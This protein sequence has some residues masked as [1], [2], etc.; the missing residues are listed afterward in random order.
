MASNSPAPTVTVSTAGKPP[1]LLGTSPKDLRSFINAAKL[2]FTL[3]K[4][5]TDAEKI[6]WTGAGLTNFPELESW[7]L[8]N[9]TSHE[10]KTFDTFLADLQKRAL[11]FDFVWTMEGRIRTSKQGE[12]DYATWSQELRSDQ[13]LLTDKVMPTHELV[14]NLLFNMDDELSAILRR[15]KA[16]EGTGFHEDDQSA[17]FL[18]KD[19]DTKTNQPVDYEKFD[20]TARDEWERIAQRRAANVAQIKALAKKGATGSSTGPA[21]SGSNTR[22]PT[23]STSAFTSTTETATKLAKL[24]QHEKDW[25]SANAGCFKCRKLRAGHEARDCKEWAKPGEVIVIPAGWKTGTPVPPTTSTT[26]STSKAT[27]TVGAVQVDRGVDLPESFAED[28]DT[29][30]DEYALPLLRLV[31]GSGQKGTAANALADSG[32]HVSLISDEFVK[33]LG[34][35]AFPLAHPVACRM[36]FSQRGPVHSIKLFVRIRLRLENGSWS[37]GETSLL[38]APLER[39]LDVI[40]GCNFLRRHR[41]SVVMYPEPRLLRH[42]QPPLEPHDLYADVQG[43]MT[44]AEALAEMDDDGRDALLGQAMETLIARVEASTDKEREMV[45]RSRRLMDEFADVFPDVLPALTEDYLSRIATRHRIRLQDPS[46]RQNQRGFNVP[47]KWRER[48]K[49][50]LEEHLASGRLRPSSSPYAS[51]AFVIPKKDPSADPRWVNDYRALNDNTIKDRTPLPIPDE[52]LADAALAKIW[53]KI[54]LTNAFFQTPL[55]EE[56]IQKTAIKT[57]WGLFEWTVMPQGLCNAPA[58]HQS[59]IN[60]ALRHLIGTCCQAFVDDVIIYS[61]SLAEHEDNCRKVLDALR[62]AGLYASRKKTELFTVRTSFLGH[63]ISRGGISADDSKVDKIRNWNRPRSVAQVRGFLGLVQYLRKFIPQ[64]AKHTAILT[65]LTKKGVVDILRLWTDRH[66]QSFEAIKRIVTSLPVLKPVD[67]S[68][69][70]PIWLMTDASKVGVGAVLLQGE[71]WRTAHPCGFWSRQYIAAEKNYPTHEQELLAIVAALK[72][73]Q[74]E[75]LGV[76]FRVLTDHDTLRHLRTQQTLSK[77]QARWVETLADYDFDLAYLPGKKNAVADSMSRFSFPNAPT[78]AVCGISTV[79]LSADFLERVR[80]GYATDDFVDQ[81]ARNATSVPGF[82]R[83]N[84]LWYLEED[85]LVVPADR[86]LRE[87]LLHDSHDALGHF[88]P[89][90][91]LA[92]LAQSF[93]WPAMAKQVEE[94][95]G[96]CD[97]CQRHKART[98]RHKGKLH[99][100]PVPPRPFSDVAL[101]FVGPLPASAGK[102]LLLTVTDRLSGY[103]RLIP[104]RTKDGAKEVAQLVF[105]EWVRF[106]GLPERMVSDRDKLFTSKFWRALYARLGVK[107]QLSTAFHPETDG[108]SE[109]TN[110]TAIQLLRQYVSRTQKDWTKHLAAVEYAINLAV[111]DSTQTSPFEMVLGFCPAIT[112]PVDSTPSSMPAVEWTLESRQHQLKMARDALAAAKVRQ[113]EQANKKRGVEHDFRV[114]DRV[115]VDSSDRRSRFKTRSRDSRAAKLFPRWDGPYE[116]VETF[117]TTSTYRLALPP[118]DRAHPVFHASKLKLYKENDKTQYPGREPARP[119]PIDVEGEQEWQI[120]AIVD[121]KG[122]G[123]QRQFLVKWTGY[124]DSENTWEPLA[125]VEDTAALDD[126]ERRQRGEEEGG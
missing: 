44:Q 111:N 78:V 51:A 85:R 101:D 19:S 83:R 80:D 28:S 41:I 90:K 125:H 79:S 67:Q 116:V 117:P 109:R 37:A 57:P 33:E 4:I 13:L 114:G 8:S 123:S 49:A 126:W 73:W 81:L 69:K 3:K 120:E 121:E 76:R 71:D 5:T 66:E 96:L 110:K 118:T 102:D 9:Q 88:G 17:L 104:C 30:S 39:P 64:L 100:L 68:S 48:W 14:K 21:S 29:D 108:R 1:L 62:S 25:L 40:L 54:D 31:L 11:P 10:A 89:K 63:V 34:L 65:P 20:R 113:A 95:V 42:Q 50:M 70:A 75:L 86:E 16:L 112:A 61:N 98:T 52:V 26:T 35:R 84:G 92:A 94:Y 107:L 119:E 56:D 46:R 24:T 18:A 105:D 55:A 6:T 93:Y 103:T 59:R 43:P 122:K 97:G 99:A 77:R 82:S 53:G 74:L 124:P 2:F 115:M 32:S 72:A 38:V 12:K 106:F 47:R 58:T 36:A 15:G 91:T 22:R 45:E 27:V 7:Y 87:V 60:E 23:S